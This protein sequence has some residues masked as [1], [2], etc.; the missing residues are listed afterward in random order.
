[1]GTT[2]SGGATA[3]SSTVATT[4]TAAS[5]GSGGSG[6]DIGQPSDKYPAPFPSPPQVVWYGGPVLKAPKIVPI[7]FSNYDTTLASSIE[8][9]VSKLGPSQYWTATTQE[10]TVG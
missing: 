2:G 1:G 3:A 7:F 10:Y 4:T 5:T 8:D 6:P 9:F